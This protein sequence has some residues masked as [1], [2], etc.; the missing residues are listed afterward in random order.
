M[1]YFYH[2][3]M[4]DILRTR[5]FEPKNKDAAVDWREP[6][7]RNEY[8]STDMVS[9]VSIVTVRQAVGPMNHLPNVDGFG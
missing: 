8:S 5:A 1:W 6:H 7:D 4:E 9:S 3:V 2:R